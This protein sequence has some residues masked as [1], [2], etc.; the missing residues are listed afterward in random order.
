M[1]GIVQGDARALP[2]VD[3]SIDL[4]ITSPPYFLLRDYDAGPA[5]IGME[6]TPAAFVDA[7]IS[8]TEE[9]V[10]VLKPKGSIFVNLGDKYNAYNASRGDGTIQK[11]GVRQVVERGHGLDVKGVR[12]KSLLGI[13]WRYAIRC[14][15]D[16]QLVLRQEIIWDKV[17][18]LPERVRDRARRTHET[19][20][21]LTKSD[22]YWYNANARED[23]SVRRVALAPYR[24]PAS[25]GLKHPAQFPP[26]WVR[27]AVGGWC[28][29]GGV[30]LDPFGG[31]GTTALV[32]REMG[33]SG[34]SLDL[35]HS[36]GLLARRRMGLS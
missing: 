17:G 24:P 7:L 16:L 30:V 19:W 3:K 36:Y 35:S 8:A 9:M 15:D 27:W 22:R 28:P 34:I 23:S 6:P 18:G 13:P 4:I 12:N 1:S 26:A 10:R 11:N 33:R 20:F 31:G 29:P 21:H 32:A 2:L 5:Q 14:V 25:W